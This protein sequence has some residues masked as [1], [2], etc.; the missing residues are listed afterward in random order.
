MAAAHDQFVR[1]GYVGANVDVIAEAAGVAK[2]TVYNIYGDKETLFRAVVDEAIGIAERFSR[3]LGDRIAADG[4]EDVAAELVRAVLGPRVLPLRRMLIGESARF[5]ELA[6]AYYDRAP[7]LVM[8]TF[9]AYLSTRTDLAVDDT[10]LAAEH[11]AF[12][13]LGAPLDQALFDAAAVPTDLDA[14]AR[15]GV[16][17]FLRAYAVARG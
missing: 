10:A 16:A 13:V 1:H 17:V 11:L 6:R 15:A 8:R 3:D 12:L 7:G 14:R 9:A 2:R 4:L 5:P